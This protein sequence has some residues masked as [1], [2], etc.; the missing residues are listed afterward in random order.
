MTGIAPV[1]PDSG[2]G[3]WTVRESL[4]LRIPAPVITAA[5]SARF[6]SQGQGDY[7]AKVLSRMRHAF[8]GHA[9]HSAVDDKKS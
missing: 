6:T 2:E 7:S 8:G 3:R 9:M 5:L 1:V 4:D